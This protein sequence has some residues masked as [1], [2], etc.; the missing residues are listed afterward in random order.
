MASPFATLLRGLE[1]NR[2]LATLPF[3]AIS[4]LTEALCARH[5]QTAGGATTIVDPYSPESVPAS[6]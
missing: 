1:T 2:D 4:V 5:H 6:N 3:G